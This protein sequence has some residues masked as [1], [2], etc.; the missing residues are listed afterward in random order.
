MK[1]FLL[2]AVLAAALPQASW[3]ADPIKIGYAISKTGRA[4]LLGVDV[5]RF[6]SIDGPRPRTTRRK[7]RR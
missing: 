6:G 1:K 5:S 2:A 7:R 4:A 3:A